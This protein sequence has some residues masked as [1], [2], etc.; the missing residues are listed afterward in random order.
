MQSYIRECS[1]CQHQ[2]VFP[3]DAQSYECSRC[4][5]LNFR[6]RARNEALN[7]FQR[8]DELREGGDFTQAA[9]SY[10]RVLEAHPD[11]HEA[12]WSLVLCKY[13]IVY[14]EDR[15]TGRWHPTVGAVS[16]DLVQEDPDFLKACRLADEEGEGGS[17][18]YRSDARYIDDTMAQIRQLRESCAPFDVFICHKTSPLGGEGYTEDYRR[19]AKLYQ[20]LTEMGYNVFFAPEKM[21]LLSG[22]S[23]YEAG[24]FHALSTARIM[25]VVCSSREHLESTW[26][27]S[28]WRRY[29]NMIAQGEKKA[30]LPLRYAD[31]PVEQLP[32]AFRMRHLQAVSMGEQDSMQIVLAKVKQYA[33]EP[34]SSRKPLKYAPEADFTVEAAEGGCSVT[35]Y[36]GTALRVKMPPAIRGMKVVKVG[37][38]AFF[39]QASLTEVLLPESVR[40]IDELAFGGCSG[41]T[42]IS[43]PGGVLSIGESAFLGCTG[44]TA[45][46]LPAG[47]Q[48]ISEKAFCGCS[49]LASFTLPASVQRIGARAFFGCG[50]LTA[51]T[52]PGALQHIGSGAFMYCTGL[53]KLALPEGV[54]SI[55]QGAFLGCTGLI[56]Q[57][58]R[59]SEAQRY[60]MQ[61]GVTYQAL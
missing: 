22:A 30:L 41:L 46:T 12:L 25:L 13:R 43:L 27:R 33:G 58:R 59:D 9:Q 55:G 3:E 26:V 44:L 47:L 15:K 19:G 60:A 5:T 32:E 10:Q 42:A 40:A 8:A 24:I 54:R 52:L 34:E 39:G 45:I 14:E 11:E 6:R 49:S 1:V 56:L 50:A 23:S 37:R 48:S 51:L 18:K 17:E 4:F 7:V 16:H 20:T 31:M 57:G 21:E 2:I 35:R 28:E 29:L 61:N 53:E 36:T 38:A